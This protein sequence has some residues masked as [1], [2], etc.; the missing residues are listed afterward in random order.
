MP[1]K[2]SWLLRARR[3]WPTM[4]MVALM[5]LTAYDI[6]DRHHSNVSP[7]TQY[8]VSQAEHEVPL[9]PR[10]NVPSK[11]LKLNDQD[12]LWYVRIPKTPEP[13]M[14]GCSKSALHCNPNEAPTFAVTIRK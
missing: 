9:V 8:V 14:M 10:E 2:P 4:I 13:F 11:D 5:L 3:Y 7:K 12:G 6:Y 1:A